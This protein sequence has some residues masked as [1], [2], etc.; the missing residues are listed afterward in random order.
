MTCE[1]SRN[2]ISLP[3][4]AAGA[5]HSVWPDGLTDALF[6]PDHVPVSHSLTP[7]SDEEP[8]TNG[9]CGQR[10]SNSSKKSA[11]RSSSASKSH[12]QKLSELSL[13]LLSLSRFKQANTPEQIKSR[14]AS[15]HSALSALIVDGSM[16]YQQTW[17]QQVTP[18][19]RTYWEHIASARRT[20]DSDCTGWPT[21]N[22]PSGGPNTKSTAKHTGGIDL[23]GAAALT[24]GW[25][26]PTK[27]DADRSP[28]MEFTT[29][30]ITLNHAA[31]LTSWNTPR[32]MDGSNGGPNQSDGALPADA[33]IAGWGTPTASDKVR[34]DAFR[35]GREP[36]PREILGAI[37]SSSPA[38]TEKRGALN[39]DLSRWLMG[40][41][42]AWGCC[43][44]MAMQ[45]VRK[46]PPHS[47][48]P[49]KKRLSKKQRQQILESIL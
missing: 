9:T 2:A 43:G 25:P 22:T 31:N 3:A 32:A 46:R 44:A 21:P 10:S 26:T 1:D 7:E 35:N 28:S 13:R 17:K 23:E 19:G 37:T 18:S 39:P 12:P 6:G 14:N 15:L 38:A 34:S 41:P 27:T 4:S 16:E 42:A 45:S 20:S 24:A 49:T 40:Y 30:N 48:G 11:R 47:S 36:T 33:G 29:P 8:Q 5:T